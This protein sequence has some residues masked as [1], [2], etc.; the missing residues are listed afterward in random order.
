[1]PKCLG[2]LFGSEANDP[3]AIAQLFAMEL[4]WEDTSRSPSTGELL[5]A[6]TTEAAVLRQAM[7]STAPS[8]SDVALMRRITSAVG[9]IKDLESKGSDASGF[10]ARGYGSRRAVKAMVTKSL[11]SAV[12]SLIFAAP[13]PA[14]SSSSSS[15]GTNSA[16]AAGT[17]AQGSTALL[18]LA[19]TGAAMAGSKRPSLA[20][21]EKRISRQP[22]EAGSLTSEDLKKKLV[23]MAAARGTGSWPA[24]E[25]NDEAEDLVAK[26]KVVKFRQAILQ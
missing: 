2:D 17:A 13:P 1:M 5:E 15:S 11:A 6:L 7:Q 8:D 22:S 24:S 10:T 14:S 21:S 23:R 16:Q 4:G 20:G 26:P 9:L 19:E 25:H 12:K 18:P 3:P